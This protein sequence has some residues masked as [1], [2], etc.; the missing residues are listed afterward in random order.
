MNSEPNENDLALWGECL[1]ALHRYREAKGN[2]FRSFCSPDR[3]TL[4]VDIVRRE[5]ANVGKRFDVLEVVEWLEIEYQ[6]MLLEEL[7][8]LAAMLETKRSHN[9]AENILL[10]WPSEWLEANLDEPA[11]RIMERVAR[12]EY[13]YIGLA[14]FY[15]GLISIYRQV[16]L[17]TAKQLAEEAA[18]HTDPE[19]RSIGQSWLNHP[20]WSIDSHRT[21]ACS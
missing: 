18:V 3:K 14:E 16:N 9:L 20:E 8:P 10:S 13:S 12:G 1:N 11:R 6:Q 4:L 17:A 19:V 2:L 15:S 7:L 21:S 5:L